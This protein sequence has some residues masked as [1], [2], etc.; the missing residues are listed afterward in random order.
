VFCDLCSVLQRVYR[1][2]PTLCLLF[3]SA[4]SPAYVLRAGYEEAK[5]L[6]R[7]EPI[8]RMLQRTDLDAATRAKLELAL[9]VRVFARDTLHLR[10]DHSYATFARVDADA[11]VHVVT[12][13]YRLRLEPYTWWFPIVGR[14]PYKGFFSQSAA[15]GEAADLERQG[16]DTAVRPSVAF[17]TLG[18]FAD[19]LVSTLLRYD[20]AVL[21]E[22]IIHELLHNTSYLAGRADFDESFA[23]FVGSRGAIMFFASRGDEAAERQASAVWSDTLQF[24]DFLCGWTGRLRDAYAAGVA[25]TERQRLFAEGQDEFRRLPLQTLMYRDF[26]T[27]PLNNAVI[28]QHL[29]YTDRLQL[30]ED[31]FR[32]EAEDLQRTITIVLETVHKGGPDPFA[33]VESQLRPTPVTARVWSHGSGRD[34]RPSSAAAALPEADEGVQT[35]GHATPPVLGG[36]AQPRQTRRRLWP[37]APSGLSPD[38]KDLGSES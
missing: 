14:V 22:I 35:L 1:L 11:M 25:L 7:R 4:C 30:F 23:N 10:V 29:T 26:G 37:A 38:L 18:W 16:Y 34:G 8:E 13:A 27:Q 32:Q 15:E 6:W 2:L 3:L 33:A 19:P 12:A 17:S 20:R 28:L 36:E 9:A 21:A 5:I 24:S 31:L